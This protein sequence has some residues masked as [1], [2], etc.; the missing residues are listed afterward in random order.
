MKKFFSRK[1]LVMVI[2]P[3]LDIAVANGLITQE[4][5]QLIIVAI[6]GLGGIYIA[7]QGVIDAIEK[8]NQ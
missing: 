8:K 3:L 6:S 5:K 7:V 2:V 4:M 1:L